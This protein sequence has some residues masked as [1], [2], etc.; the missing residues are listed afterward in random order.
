MMKNY[1]ILFILIIILISPLSV[2]AL[3]NYGV[4]LPESLN[5][6]NS[7]IIDDG[8]LPEQHLSDSFWGKQQSNGVY[9]NCSYKYKINTSKSLNIYA[10]DKDGNSLLSN[11]SS[12]TS[13]KIDAGTHIGLNIRDTYNA[14]YQIIPEV[15]GYKKVYTTLY[16]V[17]CIYRN[18]SSNNN[19]NNGNHIVN[20][21]AVSRV[22]NYTSEDNNISQVKI[23]DCAIHNYEISTYYQYYQCTK[24]T[25]CVS[26]KTSTITNSGQQ[27]ET[28]TVPQNIKDKCI[29]DSVTS[30]KRMV[31]SS[32]SHVN[33]SIELTNSN[34]ASGNNITTND[35]NFKSLGWGSS[36][37]TALSNTYSYYV[38]YGMANVCMNAKT[39]EVKYR[40]KTD[41]CHVNEGE[42]T[43]P[44]IKYEGV[45][46]FNYFIPLDAKSSDSLYLSVSKS[47][48]TYKY[49]VCL[50]AMDSNST[51]KNF[52]V[53]DNND[54]EVF[55]SDS[56]LA[57]DRLILNKCKNRNSCC[58]IET[59]IIIN[60]K[61]SF[62][63]ETDGKID[64]FSFYYRPININNP[65]PKGISDN[66]L[67]YQK[68]VNFSNSFSKSPSYIAS[69]T[70]ME[71]V[72][73]I[74]DGYFK[75]NSISLN[76]RSS[77]I[78][79]S[80]DEVIATR[81]GATTVFELG[82]GETVGQKNGVSCLRDTSKKNV[83]F[84]NC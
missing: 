9:Y 49:N 24:F 78:S 34:T 76:G 22:I 14:S 25:G 42:I 56:S 79:G 1:R 43:V 19:N 80:G 7:T 12:E 40:T 53:L 18:E 4:T 65:F 55:P 28:V 54:Y 16:N 58:H 50:N 23:T 47:S 64:G 5:S 52:L 71:N 59:R 66:S 45:E 48:E 11:K 60:H 20:E 44:N 17:K 70:N 27:E 13:I 74:R 51:Y 46:F 36:S 57:N 31:E 82:S 75:W 2:Y 67:W 29:K 62:Y 3:D 77:R 35:Y 26:T 38:E 83:L 61:N 68:D 41:S 32:A 84:N 63:K 81:N 39:G 73:N 6:N 21:D 8:T 15:S 10:I 69:S 72:K 30:I 37:A 33:Y